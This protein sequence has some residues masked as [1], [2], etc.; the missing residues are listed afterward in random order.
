MKLTFTFNYQ[1]RPASVE[2]KDFTVTFLKHMN[3]ICLPLVAL[4][5]GVAACGDDGGDGDP[6]SPDASVDQTPDAGEQGVCAVTP[7]AWS[8]PAF[9][10]NAL[11]ALALRAQLDTLIGA[12]TMRGAE[13]GDVVVA[14]SDLTTAYEAGTPSLKGSV[15]PEIDAIVLDVFGEFIPMVAA[16]PTDLMDDQ[17]SWIETTNGGLYATSPRGINAGGIEIRQIVDKGL[18]GGGVL[19]KYAL[20]QTEGTITE[21]TIDDLAAAWG[22]DAALDP[23]NKTDSAN[24]SHRMGF[25][26]AIAQALTDAKAYAADANCGAERDAALVSFFR[27]WEQALVARTVFYANAA[28]QVLAIAGTDEEWGDALHELAEGLGLTIGFYGLPD[29]SSGPLSGN[30]RLISDAD[31]ES[32][33]TDLGVDLTDLGASTT[34]ES[35]ADPSAFAT[36]VT[37]VEAT[38]M[39]IFGLTAGEVAAFRAPTA[40]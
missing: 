15:T 5:F 10:T 19:Y 23:E 13:T 34:G 30:G 31:I 35:I 9:D 27:T 39:T 40:G 2:N 7:G 1:P 16:G 26:G 36:S 21:A 33:M 4:V 38:V 24:Y 14:A 3:L 25:H 28:S 29:P 17:G 32:M 22:S 12:A 37:A 18:F 6:A 20:E 8:A 11:T